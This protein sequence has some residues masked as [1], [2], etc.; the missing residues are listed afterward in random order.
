MRK[1][2]YCGKEMDDSEVI[3]KTINCWTPYTGH[4]LDY[5]EE[6]CPYCGHASELIE[7]QFEEF[8]V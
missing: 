7:D 3:K 1:C 6:K 8:W 4:D 2:G 5:V